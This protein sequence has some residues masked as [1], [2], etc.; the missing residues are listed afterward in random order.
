MK[1]L[2]GLGITALWLVSIVYVYGT[3]ALVGKFMPQMAEWPMSQSA[4][5]LNF[6]MGDFQPCGGAPAL[7]CG[8]R[9]TGDRVAVDCGDYEGPGTAVLLTFG[10]SNSANAGR[11]RYFP[12]GDVANFNIHDG[13]CYKA[14]DPLLGPD[15]AGGSVWGVL[16][17]KLI[18][19]GDYD[20]VMVIPFGIGGS[21]LAQWQEGAYLHPILRHAAQ[22]VREAGVTPTH[23]LWH[24]GES[25]AGS[26]TSEAD[27]TAMFS[28]LLG[29]LRE[30]GIEAPVYPAVATHCEMP[31]FERDPAY[32]GGQRTV[33]AA[34]AKLPQLEG[35]RAGPDTDAIQGLDFRHDNCH[36][37]SKG[38]QAHS[39]LWYQ[40]LVGPAS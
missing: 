28:S 33:R 19:R 5:V 3:G 31:Y 39:E 27:Y 24:Q 38:M 11:D 4:K 12:L 1:W 32:E 2:I 21:A 16:A 7:E 37:N 23:V 22:A 29:K 34:Q 18:A 6:F 30:Y 14:E 20:K 25:D 15:G 26:G 36:F 9:K 10:Q 35:V 8:Y 13:R 17:D 40:A